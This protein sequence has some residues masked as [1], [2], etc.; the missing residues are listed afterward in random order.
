MAQKAIGIDAST[1]PPYRTFL[2]RLCLCIVWLLLCA[3]VSQAEE[4]DWNLYMA[5]GVKAYQNGNEAD[6]ET[7]YLAA[8]DTLKNAP[9]DDPRLATTLNA[10][11]VLYHHQRKFAAATPLYE[12]VLA[13][14]EKTLPAEHPVIAHT[15]N[16]LAI[17]YEAQ[18]NVTKAE[19]LY[20]RA[21]PLLERA[22]GKDH[23][24]VAA[25]LNNYADLL[26]KAQR[27]AEA[28][29]YENR[30]RSIWDTYRKEQALKQAP[31]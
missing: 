4:P 7:L 8:L 2:H 9:T 28:E 10:L 31:R 27:E 5:E 24:S 29:F 1:R 23:T 16:N 19:T 3:V 17:V 18:G 14:L 15:L 21:I 12:Q 25:A 26:R 13:L 6:A 30:A 11:A 20:Q 22:L